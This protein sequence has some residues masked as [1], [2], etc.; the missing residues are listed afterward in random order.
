MWSLKSSFQVELPNWEV[1]S[2]VEVK[3]SNLCNVDLKHQ[4]AIACEVLISKFNFKFEFKRSTSNLIWNFNLKTWLEASIWNFNLQFQFDFLAL[5]LRL[6]ISSEHFSV[7]TKFVRTCEIEKIIIRAEIVRTKFVRTHVVHNV[8][9]K[10]FQIEK[11]CPEQGIY[12]FMRMR[13]CAPFFCSN[14]IPPCDVRQGSS[15]SARDAVQRGCQFRSHVK[16]CADEIRQ[17]CARC[18][19]CE[20]NSFARTAENLVHSDR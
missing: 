8:V 13:S 17:L 7:R 10:R 5:D 2:K 6:D 12:L 4:L 16:E 15:L 18:L 14:R 11:R 20:R 3:I 9:Q 1:L 19:A